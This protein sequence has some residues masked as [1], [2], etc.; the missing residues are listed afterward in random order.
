MD[1][2]EVEKKDVEKEEGGAVLEV[3][4]KVKFNIL[5]EYMVVP[6]YQKVLILEE[7][8]RILYKVVE[9]TLKEEEENI[10]RRI[11]E[12]IEY[13]DD[14]VSIDI[15]KN[16]ESKRKYIS[17][18]T[19]Q[20]LKQFK[21]D[22]DRWETIKYYILRDLV[23][24]GRIDILMN[25]DFIEDISCNG[26]QLPIYVYHMRF[27]YLPTNIVFEDEDE[28]T[29]LVYRLSIMAGKMISVANPSIEGIL[30]DGSRVVCSLK[31]VSLRGP[32]FTIRKY[33]RVPFT[34]VDLIKS[35]TI[36]PEVGAYLWMLVQHRMSVIIAGEVGAGKT[37]LSNAIM[38]FIDKNSKIITIE[39]T[40]E[41][42]LS[43]FQNWTQKV[44]RESVRTD[45]RSID[46]FELVKTALRERPDYI[47]V[48][49]VRGRET[50][51]LFQAIA[52]GHGGLTTLHADSAESAIT[53]LTSR[54]LDIPPY[55]LSLISSIIVVGKVVTDTSIK[56][57]VL[58]IKEVESVEGDEVSLREIYR[59]DPASDTI[60]MVGESII[61]SKIA[62]EHG[63]SDEDLRREFNNR[64]ML[65]TV[66]SF[67]ES[68]TWD[69]FLDI[70]NQY[71]KDP[72]GTLE[73]V[74]KE[75][76]G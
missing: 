24:Y 56:R 22:R 50:Y 74:R 55:L 4:E 33:K 7:A 45:V 38:A 26:I 21:V 53:R 57:R 49:E 41:I 29:K 25:D 40:P 31:M 5:D 65:L 13:R 58:S 9:P 1:R 73:R 28:L 68:I 16:E 3:E 14:N 8:G 67:R 46:L 18:T 34:A 39:E 52:L 76:R 69:E 70:I 11:I 37:T 64:V 17:E 47:I 44:T 15:L 10:I 60:K 20:L 36:T 71:Y 30:P 27:G 63:W 32:S 12:L 61:L 43:G 23:G 42:R 66:L 75:G 2:Q 48:G 6:H 59:Y 62:A 35:G 54:P 72:V 19:E 51:T